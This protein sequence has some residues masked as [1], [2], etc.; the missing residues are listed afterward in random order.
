MPKPGALV[1]GYL[2]SFRHPFQITR[3]VE[4]FSRRIENE[5]G[6]PIQAYHAADLHTTISDM[7]KKEGFIFDEKILESLSR[8]VEDTLNGFGK[9]KPNINFSRWLY[10]PGAIVVAG[11]PDQNFVDIS[12]AVYSLGKNRGINVRMPW[13]AHISAC[14]FTQPQ[15]SE[16]LENFFK[17]KVLEFEKLL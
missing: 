1:G 8:C 3:V 6:V 17:V 5:G 7:D 12:E 13:G 14:R 9:I 11:T 2:I 16:N 4:S 15:S 10:N